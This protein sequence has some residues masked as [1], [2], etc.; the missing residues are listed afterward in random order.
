MNLAKKTPWNQHVSSE[1]SW[2]SYTQLCFWGFPLDFFGAWFQATRLWCECCWPP[3]PIRRHATTTAPAAAPGGA[4]GAHKHQTKF[5]NKR[6]FSHENWDFAMLPTEIGISPWKLRILF[7]NNGDRLRYILGLNQPPEQ[8]G[9]GDNNW[10]LRLAH[11]KHA[12]WWLR[13]AI[14]PDIGHMGSP[15]FGAS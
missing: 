13:F 2:L 5:K 14:S 3:R 11:S 10:C 12:C 6:P 1:H 7:S 15:N 8:F 9:D 4:W